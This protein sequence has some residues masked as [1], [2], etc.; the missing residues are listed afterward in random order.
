MQF[1]Q[2]TP[3]EL[4][5]IREGKL[6]NQSGDIG[7]FEALDMA[8]TLGSGALTEIGGGLRG[9]LG[10]AYGEDLNQAVKGMENVQGLAYEPRTYG[11]QKT[12]ANVGTVLEPVGTFFEDLVQSAGSNTLEATGSPEAAAAAHTA[13]ELSPDLISAAASGVFFP[14]LRKLR[15]IPDDLSNV[16]STPPLLVNRP[17]EYT[18]TVNPTS[19]TFSNLEQNLLDLLMVGEETGNTKMTREQIARRLRGMGMTEQMLNESGVQW[20]G[21][22]PVELKGILGELRGLDRNPDLLTNAESQEIAQIWPGFK[23]EMLGQPGTTAADIFA[24]ERKA[25][26]QHL[27]PDEVDDVLSATQGNPESLEIVLE[28]FFEDDPDAAASVMADVEWARRDMATPAV[29]VDSPEAFEQRY[30]Q[31]EASLLSDQAADNPIMELATQYLSADDF[32]DAIAHLDPDDPIGTLNLAIAENTSIAQANEFLTGVESYVRRTIGAEPEARA[33]NM[34]SPEIAQVIDDFWVR[35]WADQSFNL[36]DAANAELEAFITSLPGNDRRLVRNAIRNSSDSFTLAER[37]DDRDMDGDEIVAEIEDI[38]GRDAIQ[39]YNAPDT[40]TTPVASPDD[41][42][43]VVAES[44]MDFWR[45]HYELSPESIEQLEGM[46]NNM[47]PTVREELRFPDGMEE[48]IE[49]VNDLPGGLNGEDIAARIGHIVNQDVRANY[50]KANN[51]LTGSGPWEFENVDGTKLKVEQQ[52]PNQ[53]KAVKYDANGQVQSVVYGNNP[54]RLAEELNMERAIGGDIK[55]SKWRAG[56]PKYFQEN[57]LLTDQS[58]GEVTNDAHFND[59]GLIAHARTSG[60]DVEGY[61]KAYFVDEIQSDAHKVGRKTSYLPA[62]I[63]KETG[64]RVS[65]KDQLDQAYAAQNL[66]NAQ[67]QILQSKM[68]NPRISPD[69]SAKLQ[70]E[71]DVFLEKKDAA[72][73]EIDK[74]RELSNRVDRSEAMLDIPLQDNKWI[75]SMV[76]QALNKAVERDMGGVAFSSADNQKKLYLDPI[77]E[78]HGSVDRMPPDTK[79]RYMEMQALYEQMYSK[80]IPAILKKLGKKYGVEPV[81]VRMSDPALNKG[82]GKQHWYLPITPEMKKAIKEKGVP[83]YGKLENPLLDRITEQ[84]QFGGLLGLA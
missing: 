20:K 55:W 41:I 33:F 15:K 18:A 51:A 63:D 19:N 66:L 62:T 47:P 3:E 37:L 57:I 39:Q 76:T 40:S 32:A 81:R 56:K 84:P 9:L 31:V 50:G 8:A 10:L 5:L 42:D 71:Y 38:V 14:V 30:E 44:V 34:E 11:A 43:D 59:K 28:S 72:S 49:A 16:A 82:E 26:L 78:Q 1:N 4:R 52:R 79:K 53:F 21:G 35:P 48:F 2:L 45:G 64:V 24:A 60:R 69:Q 22:E 65:K 12:L 67:L 29:D 61:G 54:D 25:L 73:A 74:L 80:T 7:L 27:R 13:T 46:L 17:P 77:I 23:A 70:A 6:P 75:N 68:D 36:S 83:M 58:V